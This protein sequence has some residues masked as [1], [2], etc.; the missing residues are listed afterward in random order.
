MK[1]ITYES[2][3]FATLLFSSTA[4]FGLLLTD[5]VTTQSPDE[6]RHQDSTDLKVDSRSDSES[7]DHL[8]VGSFMVRTSPLA[9]AAST[10]MFVSF[11]NLSSPGRFTNSLV[12]FTLHLHFFSP[13]LKSQSI[14]HPVHSFFYLR[15]LLA[16]FLLINYSTIIHS[17]FIIMLYDLFTCKFYF[18]SFS[19]FFS[20]LL[21]CFCGASHALHLLIDLMTIR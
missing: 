7:T 5:E 19:S 20:R 12:S 4:V 14:M 15:L 1:Y 9:S 10:L 21:F 8:P 16:P 3:F 18:A 6:T 17:T 13:P 2:I 11:K